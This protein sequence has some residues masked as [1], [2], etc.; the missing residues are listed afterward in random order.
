MNVI[1]PMAGMGTR[2]RPLTLVTTKPLIKLSG[3]T[4]IYRIVDYLF[5]NL[6]IQSEIKTIGFI[7]SKKS[8]LIEKYLQI[9]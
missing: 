4:I 2:L 8:P 6:G 1:I 9:L 7:L 3:K 5:N